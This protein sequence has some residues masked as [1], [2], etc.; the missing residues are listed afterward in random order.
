MV[1]DGNQVFGLDIEPGIW[2]FDTH[3]YIYIKTGVL[4]SFLITMVRH[5]NQGIWKFL[6]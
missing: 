4:D 6:G 1:R 2:V 5:Q 3:G